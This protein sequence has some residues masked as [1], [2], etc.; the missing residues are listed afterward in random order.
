MGVEMNKKNLLL[1]FLKK[2]KNE[3][4]FMSILFAVYTF[5]E[6]A[7]LASLYPLLK[8]TIESESL[9]NA[10]FV[11]RSLDNIVDIIPVQDKVI[12]SAVV[13]FLL[14]LLSSIFGFSSDFLSKYFQFKISQ[15]Y[16]NNIYDSLINKPASF[17]FN[18]KQGDLTYI[19]INAS[20]SV[21]ELFHYLPKTLIE[22]CRVLIIIAFLFTMSF[23][24]TL[25][26]LILI[27]LAG[28]SYLYLTTKI[29]YP[30]AQEIQKQT[31]EQTSLFIESMQGAVEIQTY[32]ATNFF[33]IKYKAIVNELTKSLVKNSVY[34]AIPK[35]V[36]TFVIVSFLCLVLVFLKLYHPDIYKSSMP[37]FA[38]YLISIQKMIM[39]VMN[40]GN[41]WAGLK[42]LTPRLEILQENINHE[43][44]LSKDI[45]EED[46][47][48]SIALSHVEFGYS[49]CEKVLADFNLTIQ[50]NKFVAI[51]GPSGSGKSTVMNLLSGAYFCDKGSVTF[52]KTLSSPESISSIRSQMSVVTQSPFLFNS[53]IFENIRVSKSGATQ[54]EVELAASAAF[55][56]EFINLMPDGYDTV[57][58]DRGAKLSGGQRQRIAIARS[59]LKKPKVLLLDEATSALDNVSEAKIKSALNELK[60]H[61]TLVIVAHRLSTVENADEIIV[62][63][64]GRIVQKGTHHNLLQNVDGDYFKLYYSGDPK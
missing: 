53:T 16:I 50:E 63:N 36:G 60:G 23:K 49:D 35:H 33:L 19:G 30:L 52:G 38:I 6:T 34:I 9:A 12:S 8:T 15:D 10:G 61:L 46:F 11:L 13:L 47:V 20:Q 55:A 28:L 4:F 64:N 40:I 57:I 32:K 29:I 41:N 1:F 43:I 56:D 7:F 58:G 2:Y 5:L 48:G 3:V 37:I 27:T 62:M 26:V 21:G 39:S 17:I 24:V 44:R 42:S 31:S 18:M 54:D 51:V 22:L 45:P 59:L 25:F 14:G